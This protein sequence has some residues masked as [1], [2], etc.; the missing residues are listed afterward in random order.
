MPTRAGKL[1]AREFLFYTE[2]LALA[3]LPG[4]FPRP[5]RRVMWMVLQFY[6]RNPAIHF[7]LHP[8]PSRGRIEV[9]LHFESTVE[10][11]EAWAQRIAD[12]ACEVMATMGPEWELEEWTA[13]WRRLHRTFPFEELT[14]GLGREVAAEFARAMQSLFPYAQPEI[15]LLPT[16]IVTGLPEAGVRHQLVR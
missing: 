7:E 15:E 6:W 14:T 11:N 2:D 1:K 9:G 16:A 12:N 10:Q 3:S 8:Q 5:E 4:D 13:S